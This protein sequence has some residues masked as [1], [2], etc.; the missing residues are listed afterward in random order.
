M[1][2]YTTAQDLVNDV[3]FRANEPTDGTSDF[4]SQA[5]QYLNRAYQGIWSGGSELV[6]TVNEQWWWLRADA[7][8]TIILNPIIKA[9]TANVTHNSTSITMS[10][11]IDNAVSGRFFQSD[12]HADMFLISTHTASTVGITL[13]A[14]YT[15]T[16]A[17]AA[18]YKILQYDYQLATDVLSLRGP[19]RYYQDS[20]GH[21]NMVGLSELQSEW[22]MNNVHVGV[23]QQFSMVGERKV[24][25]SHA[26]RDG[27]AT[28]DLIKIDYDYSAEPADLTDSSGS[29]P[30]VPRQ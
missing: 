24:R 18:S 28:T 20:G 25:F 19:M 13:N 1:A 29:I 15:G 6:P 16:T 10:A 14:A 12:D 17:T 26:G 11:Q 30:L 7:Q 4:D 8:G 21:I 5:L 2:N 9:G 27:T 3:L 22:P 23:P